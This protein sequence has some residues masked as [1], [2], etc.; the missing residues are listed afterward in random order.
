MKYHGNVTV[1]VYDHGGN[2]VDTRLFTPATDYTWTY[3]VPTADTEPYRYVFE[4]ETEVDQ[5]AIDLTGS[6]VKLNNDSEG[7][8]GKDSEGITVGPKESTS[9]TKEVVS[10]NEQE[11]TWIS[12]IHVPESG[13][14]K[15]VV[16]DTLPSIY[17]GNLGLSGN[18][19]LYDQYEE[20]S[21]E[22][23][24]IL[25]NQE[26]H[27]SYTVDA[28][29]DKIV[30]TFYK[31]LGKT[32]EGLNGTP[33][34]RDITVKLTTKVNQ[35]WLKAGY[36]YPTSYQSFHT[37]KIKI[38]GSDD[39]Q[40]SVKYIEPSIEKTG[41][42]TGK[43]VYKYTIYVTHVDSSPII[44]NDKFDKSVLE[45]DTSLD[46]HDWNKQSMY[47]TGGDY[48]G[49]VYSG[50][51]SQKVDYAD[52]TDGIQIT[53]NNVPLQDNGQF[54]PTYMITYF[55]KLKEGVDL[56][57][58]AI[59]NGGQYDLKNTALWNGHESE[60]TFT[61]TY[62]YL[63]KKLLNEGHL[64]GTNRKAQY[65]IT[66]NS[67]K[68]TLNGGEP[69]VMTDTMSKN[70][71]V[72]YSSIHIVTDP[73]GQE[74]PYSLSG[75]A[76]G[77]TVATYTVPDFTKVVITYDALV[78]GNAS[79]TIVNKVTV[80][81]KDKEVSTTKS[82]GH[83]SEGQG[84]IASFKIIKVDG[85]DANKKLE[86][87][88]FRIFAENPE[89][90]FGEKHHH[91]KELLLE[92]DA[93]G[94][95]ILDGAEYQILFNEKYY[96]QEVAA[97]E[98]YGTISF[99][100]EVTLTNDMQQ[101]NYNTG[102]WI[103]YYSDTMQI[104]NWPLEGLIVEKQ[105]ESTNN[106]DKE[107]YYKFRVSILN[108]DGTVNTEYNEKNGDDQFE[109]GSV[110]FELKDK[111][112]KMFWGFQKGTKYKVEEIDSK[113]L[114]V[115]V[116]YK[117]YDA[118]GNVTQ[119]I[120]NPSASHIGTLTQQNEII[121]F[122]NSR[123]EQKGALKLTKKVTVNGVEIPATAT[124]E[125]KKAADGTYIFK[126]ESGESITPS[127]TKYVEITVTDGKAASY[128][129]ADT[130]LDLENADAVQG[131]WVIINNLVPG[132]Y[133]ITEETPTNGTSISEINNQTT[134]SY[135]TTVTVVAGDTAAAQA[136][137]TFTNNVDLGFLEITK[138]IQR[139]GMI[140]ASATG[141]FYYAVYNAEYN[142]SANPAQVP[143][144]T[145]SIDVTTDGSGKA[146][147]SNLPFGKY[148]VYELTGE[149]DKGGTPIVSGENG[150]QKVI[151]DTIYTVTGSGTTAT[152]DSSTSAAKAT[153]INNVETTSIE[154]TKAW[155]RNGTGIDWPDD[156]ASVD[157]TL[158]AKIGDGEGTAPV[159]VNADSVKDYFTDITATVTIVKGTGTS[160]AKASWSNLPT[161]VLIPAVEANPENGIEAK[162]AE[163][164]D[165]TYSVVETG[166]TYTEA[167]G[168]AALTTQE[169]I[170]AAFNPQW[171][172]TANTITNNITDFEFTKIWNDSA[173]QNADWKKDTEIVVT[174]QRRISTEGTAEIVGKYTIKKTGDG[175][176]ASDFTV[177][178]DSSTSTA[179]DLTRKP[180]ESNTFQI[181]GLQT[182][183]TIG[184]IT[185]EY[186]YFA[187]EEAVTG[188][189]TT[190][191]NPTVSGGSTPA[192]YVVNGGSIINTPQGGYELPQTGG[193]GTTL[194]T[195]LGGLMTVTAGAILTIKR[196]RR[197]KEQH[198]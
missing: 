171:D 144:R 122:K 146:T 143:V 40:A 52:T 166:V 74:V 81:G 167:S 56:E 198:A 51:G 164:K 16:T 28:S 184:E 193:I 158:F 43:G 132:G 44:I 29:S 113:G 124:V 127:V 50:D 64:G 115:S 194:F 120:T 57:Q 60:F 33:G 168:K 48:P 77:T 162:A 66:F 76:G 92:T 134:T 191:R 67:A 175:K 145:G 133:T 15:A 37:N 128:K 49:H 59:A 188:Y 156:I 14:S 24:G 105:V 190:Y 159:A 182:L 4:Y 95:I 68:A 195:A 160:P 42:Q 41:L 12:H 197:R 97:P 183:G 173:Q 155:K 157:F 13:L 119:T 91:D 123:E 87:V 18:Y 62:D 58:L 138:N 17:S 32:E 34:G 96:V 150:V 27:E 73:A 22:I 25:E 93:K 148:Y 53:A 54:F 179:P 111:E 135:S 101:V 141:T 99:P 78:I 114:A 94:E 103:Y 172:A 6:S 149:P 165:V 70:L 19:M 8:G 30:I 20:G 189:Q 178:K 192:D 35:D 152:V 137:A 187:T 104:K 72:D 196:S 90:D 126:V 169:A 109:N 2:L 45:L 177:T 11:I 39:V 84:A 121:S 75:G 129:V 3:T 9:I 63:D 80:N 163:W 108:D 5:A 10:S 116:T 98:N 88:Q 112:Q 136:S 151:S 36:D 139:N 102:I 23:T 181:T 147:E 142:A 55:L 153:L 180:G 69:M 31:D 117:V 86:G 82:Y 26:Y 161:K 65:Q 7:P 174:V 106:N 118:D 130:K 170:S 1:K 107:Q 71:S 185:G 79:Q 154:A 176:T 38:N 47:I 83:S 125:Q 21:L 100:Y 131:E 85:Y 61:T 46:G 89:L 110:E 186:T 140:D